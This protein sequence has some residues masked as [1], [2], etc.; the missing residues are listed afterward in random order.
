MTEVSVQNLL[1]TNLEL[2]K[3]AINH[4]GLTFTSECLMKEKDFDVV[5]DFIGQDKSVGTLTRY[6]FNLRA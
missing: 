4:Q 2:L 3:D 6:N 1:S 5:N